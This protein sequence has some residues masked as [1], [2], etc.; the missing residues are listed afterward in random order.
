M[1]LYKVKDLIP[2]PK[3]GKDVPVLTFSTPVILYDADS[4]GKAVGQNLN[5][6]IVP[7]MTV[8]GV[9]CLRLE[10]T[11]TTITNVTYTEPS[12]RPRRPGYLS[13]AAGTV[14][15]GDVKV[16]VRGDIDSIYYEAT[17]YKSG[18]QLNTD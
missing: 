9:E 2:A 12:S 5:Y 14:A 6:D 10:L 1:I 11:V 18:G 3:D 13:I 8:N 4:D 15:E 16:K 7:L 17:G